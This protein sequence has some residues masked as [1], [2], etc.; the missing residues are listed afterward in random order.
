[1]NRGDLIV[2][3]LCLVMVLFFL[4]AWFAPELVSI[5]FNEVGL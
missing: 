3:S 1:V 5:T 4:L 2:F